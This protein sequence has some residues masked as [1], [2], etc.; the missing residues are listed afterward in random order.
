MRNALVAAKHAAGKIDDVTGL[1]RI[2]A[3]AADDVGVAAGRNEADVLAVLLVG[4]LKAKAARQLAHLRLVHVAERETQE[5]ELLARGREQKIALVA[6]GIGCTMQR[7][8]SGGQAAR[9]DIMTGGKRSSAEVARGFQQIAEL[10]R[11]VALDARHRR[12]A[13]RVALGEIIDHGLAE[14]A[15]VV[16]HVMRN[17]DGSRDIAGVMDVATGATGAL[18]MGRRAMVV[19]L[20]R[21][22]DDIVALRLQQRSRHRRVDAAG[23][24]D[25][26]TGVL[27]TAFE[28]ETVAHGSGWS[29][30][31]AGQTPG[32]WKW[33]LKPLN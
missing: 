30:V 21:D 7:A 10:D 13:M 29:A 2:R 15:F 5:V 14:T 33:R 24:G 12:L 1:H 16:Q 9:G 4:D 22:A 31:A 26:D 20:Q 19:E 23:H 32:D 17:A 18:A 3:Q 6:I 28:I 11:A 25:H 27:G 8:R